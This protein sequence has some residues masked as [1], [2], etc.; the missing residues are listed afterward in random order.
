M[1]K[2]QTFH[3]RQTICCLV[4]TLACSAASAGRVAPSD[5]PWAC[6][7]VGEQTVPE[8]L[9]T[10]DLFRYVAQVTHV[11]PEVLDAKQWRAAL[12]L[13]MNGLSPTCP[14]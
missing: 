10:T 14:S 1:R 4:L 9:A 11:V 5:A 6:V 8:R 3:P 2:S 7:V 12:S 13:T